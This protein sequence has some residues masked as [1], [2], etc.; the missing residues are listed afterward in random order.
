MASQYS[1]IGSPAEFSEGDVVVFEEIL[2][3]GSKS[4]HLDIIPRKFSENAAGFDLFS[5]EEFTVKTGERH[6]FP[7]GVKIVKFPQGCYGRVVGR[8]SLALKSGIQIGG[9]VID[10][11]Y[12][13]EIFVLLFNCGQQAFQVKVG[14]RIAQLIFE[15]YHSPLVFKVE[16]FDAVEGCERR[17]RYFVDSNV[18]ARGTKG[19]GSTGV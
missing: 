3:E 6:L 13:G 14:D 19:F 15:K 7:T 9:G 17:Q 12:S 1:Y 11:D 16:M 2:K 4:E 10:P 18:S 5:A 8:S